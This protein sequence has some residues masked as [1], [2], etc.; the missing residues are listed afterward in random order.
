MLD[1]RN[2]LAM[3]L[4]LAA[5]PAFADE[6]DFASWLD[7]L[8]QEALEAGIQ[9]VTVARALDGL[10]PIPRVVELDRRQPEKT[11]SYEDYLEHVVSADRRK[12][13][14]EQLARN[15]PLL[16]EIGQ[17]YGVQPRFI[18]ALWGIETSYGADPGRFPII[19]ALAT[20][21]FEGRRGPF[22]RAELLNALRIVEQDGIDPA[23]MQGSWAGAM[24]QAQ[25]MP[26][27]FLAYAVSYSGDG[28][29]DIWHRR[30]DVFAS[31][32]NYLAQSGWRAD[33][34]WGRVVRLPANFDAG[35]LGLGTAKTIKQWQAL[36]VRRSDGGPLPV[37]A[38]TASV[39]RPGGEE[40]RSILVYDNFRALL[41]WNNSS[42]FASAVGFLADSME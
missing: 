3:A 12:A 26:S 5:S 29:R 17:R 42:Y 15:R 41:K 8:K 4:L 39:L 19:G 31:M 2:F 20:L 34:T 1:R 40:G 38:L 28:K 21:A 27:T 30:E 32:A 10:E 33:Q 25:F 22:F 37:K 13:A 16:T 23:E 36:G 24:G 9:P 18:V 11:R 14:R 7:G 35:L 6:P